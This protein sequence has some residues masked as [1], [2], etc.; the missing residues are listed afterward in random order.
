MRLLL[1]KSTDLWWWWW[2]GS[3][4]TFPLQ[5]YP[6]LPSF[7]APLL[8]GTSVLGPGILHLNGFPGLE[9]C[10]LY[11]RKNFKERLE[12]RLWGN[13]EGREPLGL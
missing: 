11:R 6:F 12:I 1:R 3:I 9:M 10:P 8:S 5:L 4:L 13:P 2:W 7:L